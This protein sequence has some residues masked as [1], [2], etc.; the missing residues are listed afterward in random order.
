MRAL[1]A[2]A[3]GPIGRAIDAALRMQGI[4]VRRLVRRAP[5][6]PGEFAWDPLRGALDHRALEDVDAVINLAGRSIAQGRWTARARA[7]IMESR[8]RSTRLLVET[9]STIPRRPGALVSASAIGFYGSRGDELLTEASRAGTG[10]LA[11]VATAWEREAMG[12]LRLG[13]RVVCTRFGIVLASAGGALAALLPIF[14]LGLGGPLGG[15]RQWWSWIHIDDLAAAVL[16][17]AKDARLRGPVNVVGP[18]P[19]TNRAFT[20]AL[21]SALRRPAVLPAPAVALRLVLGGMADEMILS[22]QRVIPARLQEVGFVFRWPALG[23]ALEHLVGRA[24][25]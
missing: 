19:V 18:D 5:A 13:V 15:G 24:P 21:G 17:A 2:G 10:L 4:E 11:D 7:E 8:V 25:A 14:R 1:I 16:A 3:S 6:G 20:Q 23:P 12:A 9:M 22:S